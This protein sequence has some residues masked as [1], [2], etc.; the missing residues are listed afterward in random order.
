M[1]ATRVD[2]VFYI[3]AAVWW[4]IGKPQD[5][6]S[7][8]FMLRLN[9]KGHPDDMRKSILQYAMQGKLV[10][11]RSEEGTGEELYQQ[12]Q[13]EKAE[14]IEEGKLKKK[15]AL[16]KIT[17]DKIP[18]DIPDGWKWV[19]WGEVV[20]IVSARRV[21]QA[22]WRN[23]GIPF[24]RAREIAKLAVDG[25]VDNELYISEELYDEFSQLGVPSSG[26]LMVTAVGTLGKAYIV[27]ET[28]KF[29]YKDASVICLEN[30]AKL[31][32]RYLLYLMQTP[33]M[34]MQVRSNSNGT[35]VATL[36]MVRMNEY[37]IPLPP[38]AEQQR[39]VEKLD[40]ILPHIADLKEAI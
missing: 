36:T 13:E 4:Q 39:I 5:F 38:I 37:L 9:E 20:N 29:Y 21:H 26:D 3:V 28:D 1:P 2:K 27:K 10:E 19:K 34:D 30:F 17:E 32:S 24:Y 8:A 12:I 22:D 25:Y 18:F 6:V 35:T 31:D 14:L 7:E 40:R 16:A 11:Q 15:K 23:E 33:L